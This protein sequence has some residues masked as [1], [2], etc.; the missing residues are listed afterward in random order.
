MTFKKFPFVKTRFFFLWLPISWSLAIWFVR[1]TCVDDRKINCH[2]TRKFL[3]KWITYCVV[4]QQ[5]VHQKGFLR[6]TFS[7]F[8]NWV[9]WK[10][11]KWHNWKAAL[12]VEMSPPKRKL[13][14]S[15][16]WLF[17]LEAL[18]FSVFL[19]VTMWPFNVTY[20]CTE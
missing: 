7:E 18:I 4:I 9:P 13:M 12:Q 20:S 15:R 14:G 11:E 1:Y 8:G 19:N 16:E 3:R 2:S 5:L 17:L 10:R 6:S